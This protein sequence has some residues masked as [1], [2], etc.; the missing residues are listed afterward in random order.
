MSRLSTSAST[1]LRLQGTKVV[2]DFNGWQRAGA[3]NAQPEKTHRGVVYRRRAGL[4]SSASEQKPRRSLR[5]A[6][7]RERTLE[8][9]PRKVIL[10]GHPASKSRTKLQRRRAAPRASERSRFPRGT[11]ADI[12]CAPPRS[13]ICGLIFDRDRLPTNRNS[14]HLC[15][16]CTSLPGVCDIY[17][18]RFYLH[19]VLQIS[20]M[21]SILFLC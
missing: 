20:E 6:R 17:M 15:A 2:N 7:S 1:N 21:D 4:R 10:P 13:K 14:L 9:P 19:R 8:F 16:T 11:S 12:L 5:Y 18:F 3:R